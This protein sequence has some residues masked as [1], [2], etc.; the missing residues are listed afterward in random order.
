MID[1][2]EYMYGKCHLYVLA[3]SEL[4]GSRISVFWDENALDDD[5]NVIDDICLIHAFIKIEDDKIIDADGVHDFD[6][7][8][9]S[10]PNCE[11]VYCEYDYLSFLKIVKEKKWDFF[12]KNEKENLLKFI[13]NQLKSNLP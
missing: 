9:N 1:K 6:Y 12:K 3:F 2:Y 4:S 11:P 8:L 13:Q 7:V 10:Y 5:M